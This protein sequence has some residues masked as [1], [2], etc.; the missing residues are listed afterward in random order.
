MLDFFFTQFKAD[1]DGDN[2]AGQLSKDEVTT[3][4][5]IAVSITDLY[6][7]MLILVDTAVTNSTAQ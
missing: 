2:M 6:I 7:I 4:L 1:S 5:A 3:L